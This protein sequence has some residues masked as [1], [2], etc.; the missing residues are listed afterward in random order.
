[1]PSFMVAHVKH[2]GVD[3]VLIPLEEEFDRYSP[4]DKAALVAELRK[5]SKEAGL[6][7]TVVPVWKTA[8]EHMKFVAPRDMHEL[9]KGVDVNW[10][11][12]SVNR[13]LT[14]T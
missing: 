11:L 3:L 2:K 12:A 14:W 6:L 5:R 9:F 1:M 13:D 8:N 10:V 4:E 7:G